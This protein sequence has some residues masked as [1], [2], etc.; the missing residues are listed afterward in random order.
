MHL[1]FQEYLAAR[2][3]RSRAFE[4]ETV[5]RELAL[6]FGES[7]WQEVGLLMLALEDPSLF[8]PYMQE[9]VKLPAFIKHTSLVEASLTDTAEKSAWPFFELL[10][11]HPGKD[12]ELWERQLYAL[13]IAER[14]DPGA[15]E[16]IKQKLANHPSLDIRKWITGKEEQAFLDVIRA[17]HGGYE[18][19]RIPGGVFMMGSPESEEGRIDWEGPLHR[20]MVPDF[21]MGRHP[22]TN[23]EYG[24]F[25]KDNPDVPEPEYWADRQY[26]QPRQPVV[27]VIW[28]DAKKYAKW[29]GLRRPT[30]AEWEYACRANTQTR[31]YPGDKEEDLDRAG[32]YNKNSGN[33]L[34]PVGEKEPNSFG[35]YDMHGNVWEWVEDDWH[36]NYN[37][38]PNDG[39]AWSDSPRGS[40]RVIRGG[41]WGFDAPYCRSAI[42]YGRPPSLRFN[43]LGF[44]L[45]RPVS[46]GS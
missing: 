15:I 23:E 6:H 36:D 25:L 18:L 12:K 38:G 31:Y 45:S 9:V 10:E 22:V 16:G 37:G 41:S 32:W 1:G 5:L 44:R 29:A 34:H 39:R 14:L 40:H 28:D 42:R 13:K 17:E 26:N 21:Y 27:G 33:Q 35:L 3:I 19:I 11:I 2:E 8:K 43:D 30:E 4:D 46:L 20:V 7:W 24:L